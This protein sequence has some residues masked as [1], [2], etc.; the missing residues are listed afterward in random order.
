MCGTRG[1]VKSNYRSDF[2][3]YQVC[4][5][6]IAIN[7]IHYFYGICTSVSCRLVTVIVVITTK[8]V[9]VSA[10]QRLAVPNL[11]VYR[12][13]FQAQINVGVVPRKL[14]FVKTDYSFLSVSVQSLPVSSNIY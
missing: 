5:T 14:I 12:K 6:S 3:K 1:E 9:E 11:Y 10:F 7:I 8:Y 2:I 4:S 13:L